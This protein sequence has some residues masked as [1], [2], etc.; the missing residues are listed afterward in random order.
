MNAFVLYTLLTTGIIILVVLLLAYLFRGTFLK[1]IF[2][3]TG[4]LCWLT[5][6]AAFAC[7]HY[8]LYVLIYVCP[9]LVIAALVGFKY[10]A[11]EVQRPIREI[12]SVMRSVGDGDLTVRSPEWLMKHKHEIG[13]MVLTL[14]EVIKIT[15]DVLQNARMTSQ[16]VAVASNQF[17]HQAELISKGANDQAASAEEISA[18][19]EEMVANIN[20]NLDHAKAGTV[21]SNKVNTEVAE[22]SQ[23]FDRTSEAM[24]HIQEKTMT[25]SEIARK[26]NILAIN[27][28]IEAAR[29]GEYG[30]GFAVVAAEIRRLADQSQNASLE[31]DNISNESSS[32]VQTMGATLET[33]IP[34]IEKISNL[35]HEIASASQEQQTGAEQINSALNQLVQVTNE[36]S[37]TSEELSAESEGLV[38]QSTKLEEVITHFK[39]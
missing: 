7:S 39:I 23:A 38:E 20:Q 4:L 19:M 26:T 5:G 27:A 13:Q 32:A 24:R 25:V 14:E 35:V 15:S 16:N 1:R 9:V 11:R 36:N 12:I 3:F 29:A 33:T 31:I 10:I 2:I 34:T 8:G 30:R 6:I 28:A 37:S 21:M 17:K 22:V 18:A